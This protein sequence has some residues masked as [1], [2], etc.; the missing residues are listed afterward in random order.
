MHDV[1]PNRFRVFPMF[2]GHTMGV[3]VQVAF[4]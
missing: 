3:G 4:W 2:V 1:D